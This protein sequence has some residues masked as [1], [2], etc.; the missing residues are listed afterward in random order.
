MLRFLLALSIAALA[1]LGLSI[2][3]IDA[4]LAYRYQTLIFLFLT[5]AG[6]FHFLL[7]TR[8]DRPDYFVQIYLLTMVVKILASAAYL[9][10][11]VIGQS[12]PAYDVV[13]FMGV[14][15]VFTALEI[16]FLYNKVNS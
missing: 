11:I 3:G 10:V 1:I 4:P 8:Q 7:R 13:F 2:W 15:F 12:E 6:L 14:Y 9:F 16:T 5:T